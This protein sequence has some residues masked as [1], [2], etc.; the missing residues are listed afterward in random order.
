MRKLLTLSLLLFSFNGWAETYSCKTTSL[1]NP[2][3]FTLTRLQQTKDLV[4]FN[5]QTSNSS[6]LFNI[7]R[8]SER[9]IH[10]LRDNDNSATYIILDKEFGEYIGVFMTP[11]G[12]PLDVLANCFEVDSY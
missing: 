5:E 8:E 7:V 4:Q 6:K 12:S 11:I 3:T 10:L 1:P 9:Y 2:S